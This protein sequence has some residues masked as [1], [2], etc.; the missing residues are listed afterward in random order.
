MFQRVRT[1]AEVLAG[2]LP[3]IHFQDLSSFLYTNKR[4]SPN[5]DHGL[6]FLVLE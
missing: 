3:N 1:A 6:C 5:S 2:N 4:C